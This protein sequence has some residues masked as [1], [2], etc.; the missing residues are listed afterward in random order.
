MKSIAAFFICIVGA[1]LGVYIGLWEMFIG[2]IVG[3]IEVLKSSD[4]DAYDLAINIC[5]IIF[6]GPVGWIVFYVGVIFATLISGSGK[7]KRFIRK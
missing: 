1:I 4:I 2:G 7:Y 6:A 5:K 3:L